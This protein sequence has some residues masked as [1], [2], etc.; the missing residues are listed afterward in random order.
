MTENPPASSPL[1]D[2]ERWARFVASRRFTFAKSYARTYPHEWT[3]AKAGA[4]TE[5]MWAVEYLRRAG[6][7]ETFW[8]IKGDYLYF[9]GHKYWTM[10]APSQET[11][12][13]NR[14]YP[15]PLDHAAQVPGGLGERQA[16]VWVELARLA[17]CLPIQKRK[18]VEAVCTAYL[19]N[20]LPELVTRTLFP[21]PATPEPANTSG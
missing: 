2:A 5:F 21:E 6:K 10:G 3:S 9:N 7:V 18:G 17:A 11:E 16:E 13:I 4:D 12:V 1:A 20:M 15:N 8:G 19:E 14:C